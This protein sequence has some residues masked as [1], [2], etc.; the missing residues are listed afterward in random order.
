MLDLQRQKDLIDLAGEGLL[1]RQIE[2]AR[3]L[4]RDGRSALAAGL[5]HVGE[6]GANHAQIVHAAMLIEACILDG[7]HRVLHDLGHLLDG[8]VA[9]ALFAELAQQF[10]FAR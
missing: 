10:P 7:Q 3:Y 2:I 8:R 1:G 9:A 4:H 6:T 5:A